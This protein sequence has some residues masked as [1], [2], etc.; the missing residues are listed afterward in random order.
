M[1]QQ[2]SGAMVLLWQDSGLSLGHEAE[3]RDVKEFVV[4]WQPLLEV[5]VGV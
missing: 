4:V 1:K 5:A 3:G 2:L